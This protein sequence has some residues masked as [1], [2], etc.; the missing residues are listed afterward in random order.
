MRI[1]ITGAAGLIGGEVAARLAMRGHAVTA[2]VHRRHAVVGNDRCVVMS[3]A[4]DGGAPGPG[5]VVTL[6]G[7]VRLPGLGLAAVPDVDL[8]VHAAA[9]TAFDAPAADY[10]SVNVD[11]TAHVAALGL[12]MLHVSTAYV[13]GTRGGRI[14]ENDTGTDFVNGYEASKAAGEAIV[15]AAM[16]RGL[17]AAVARPSIVVG[18]SATGAIRDFDNIYMV[19]RLIAERRV[20][21]LPGAPGASLDLVPIDHV[22]G[23]IT[24][25]VEDFDRAQ[26]TTL[27]LVAAAP[28]PLA[29]IG[30]AIAAVPGLGAPHF[31]DPDQFMPESLPPTER[32]YHAAAASLYVNYLLRGP[33]FDTANA[34]RLVPP[35]PPTGREWLDT[36][37]G[38]CLAQGFVTARRDKASPAIS[39]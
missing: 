3:Q 29:S 14:G 9:I 32:R 36:L 31:V 17:P 22:C 37:I 13:C 24:A 35:C 23:G 38:Y 8:V 15:R 28:T 11:G 33:V 21:T 2:L 16:A 20:R 34:R 1:L 4:G 12:P 26:G 27:H 39:A 5:E 25:M 18:D 19:F 30:A 10:R 7:D 6:V